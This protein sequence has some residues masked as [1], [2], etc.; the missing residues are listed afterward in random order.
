MIKRMISILLA[1]TI[2]VV[3]VWAS[4]PAESQGV[5]YTTAVRGATRN[6]PAIMVFD[7]TIEELQDL[8]T[9]IQNLMRLRRDVGSLTRVEEIQM[10]RQVADLGANINTMR[11]SQ[12]MVRISTEFAMRS[13]ITTIANTELDIQ[14]LEAT[15]RQD[16]VTLNN[17]RLRFNAGLISE[18]DFRAA[19]LALQQQ[20]ANLAAIQVSLASER[21]NLNRILQR[22]LTGNFHVVY[23]RELLELP[24]D[25]NGYIRRVT[26]RQPNVRQRELAMSR[27]RAVFRDQ[28]VDFGSPERIAR[29]RAYNQARRENDDTVR[30]V[31]T[32][33]RNQYNNL[34]ALMHQN[35]S[36]EIEL[37]RAIERRD[38]VVLNH[39]A[40]LA[41]PFDV[42]AAELVILRNEIA[43]EKNLNT[44]WNTQFIF[45]NPFLLALAQ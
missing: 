6:L 7:D 32:V 30:S 8:R 1:C 16:R 9:S 34:T 31:E 42:E 28:D 25:L 19:E 24:A 35:E 20:E 15:L 29:E 45:E 38:A 11:A 2:F 27:A 14:L 33:I 21:Q 43:I 39:Q 44:Y 22:P 40:G 3:P 5:A 12:T 26:P 23:D 10:Q 18:S 41:T 37:Q 13:S 4:E 17:T 36:L